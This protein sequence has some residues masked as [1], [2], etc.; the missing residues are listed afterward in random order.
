[1]N[2]VEDLLEEGSKAQGD[3]YRYE[4]F[5]R[6]RKK[7]LAEEFRKHREKM[8]SLQVKGVGSFLKISAPTAIITGLTAVAHTF[9][10]QVDPFLASSLA[11]TG[12]ALSGIAWW[13]EVKQQRSE[14]LQS[15]PYLYLLTLQDELKTSSS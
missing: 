13:G 1:R 11:G 14:A 7:H 3:E 8:D 12:A 9:G 6:D 15:F 10:F 2:A 5:L 4:G